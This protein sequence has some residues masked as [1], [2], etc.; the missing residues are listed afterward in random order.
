MKN[1]FSNDFVWGIHFG[2]LLSALMILG[3]YFVFGG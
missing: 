1:Y 3:T 2:I